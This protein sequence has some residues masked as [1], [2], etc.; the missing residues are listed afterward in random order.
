[1]QNL[2]NGLCYDKDEAGAIKDS[3][4]ISGITVNNHKND[5]SMYMYAFGFKEE[6]EKLEREAVMKSKQVELNDCVDFVSEL[7][8]L[9]VHT[10][11]IPELQ[12]DDDFGH[13]LKCNKGITG[14]SRLNDRVQTIAIEKGLTKEQ[15][16]QLLYV[17][18]MAGDNSEMIN[19]SRSHL[20]KVHDMVS[21]LLDS[22][23][24]KTVFSL[25]DAIE[26]H[27]PESHYTEK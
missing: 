24:Q 14:D 17:N 13:Q 16:K 2:S 1:M 25:I 15:W 26:K 6:I 18:F 7:F 8:N 9:L 20:K 12:R 5:T 10:V 11:I 27:M 22:E 3:F 21:R 4:P 23:E 19:V